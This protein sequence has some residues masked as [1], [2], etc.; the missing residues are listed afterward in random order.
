MPYK[1]IVEE[2]WIEDMDEKSLK[3]LKQNLIFRLGEYRTYILSNIIYNFETNKVIYSHFSAWWSNNYSNSKV[4]E[5]R[6]LRRAM[7]IKYG[8]EKE[9]LVNGSINYG[10]NIKIKQVLIDDDH[11]SDV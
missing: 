10:F 2:I 4:P 5:I 1:K 8:D 11:Y 9:T 6:D 3:T 7:K